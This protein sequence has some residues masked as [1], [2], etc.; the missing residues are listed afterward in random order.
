MCKYVHA[1]TLARRQASSM[2][3]AIGA[4]ESRFAALGE[5]P[6]AVGGRVRG[7]MSPGE[8]PRSLVPQ[9]AR[10]SRRTLACRRWRGAHGSVSDQLQGGRPLGWRRRPGSGRRGRSARACR[11]APASVA[12]RCSSGMVRRPTAPASAR[13]TTVASDAGG[14]PRRTSASAAGRCSWA[15]P[16]PVTARGAA[17][18]GHSGLSAQPPRYHRARAATGGP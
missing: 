2:R 3:A 4:R 6:P 7:G 9:V 1:R 16:M 14:R 5:G 13:R 11:S 15:G 12:D 18:S 10:S 8:K 17:G